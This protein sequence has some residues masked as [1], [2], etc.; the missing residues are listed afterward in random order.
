MN[1]IEIIKAT[2]YTSPNGYKLT[3]SPKDVAII[4]DANDNDVSVIGKNQAQLDEL[5]E[6]LK[7]GMNHRIKM[8]DKAIADTIHNDETHN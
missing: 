6:L 2:Q 7:F 8:L 4:K 5:Y 3:F 1:K